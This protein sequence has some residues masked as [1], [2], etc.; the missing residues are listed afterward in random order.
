MSYITPSHYTSHLKISRTSTSFKCIWTHPK[1]YMNVVPHLS[2][3]SCQRYVTGLFITKLP[4]IYYWTFHHQFITIFPR[5]NYSMHAWG[6]TR[7]VNMH[8]HIINTSFNNARLSLICKT[9]QHKQEHKH[10]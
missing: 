6:P 8:Q 1:T 4:E 5:L 9:P 10:N 2:S 3:P 7:Q